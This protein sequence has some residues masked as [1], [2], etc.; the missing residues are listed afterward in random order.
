MSLYDRTIQRMNHKRLFNSTLEGKDGKDRS[1][2]GVE[3]LP[4][5]IPQP[6][7][8]RNNTTGSKQQFERKQSSLSRSNRY[9]DLLEDLNNEKEEFRST[10][11]SKFL[12]ANLQT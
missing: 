7:S 2:N 3:T 6:G 11:E 9:K 10:G 1:L 12:G 5:A 8:N 4:R